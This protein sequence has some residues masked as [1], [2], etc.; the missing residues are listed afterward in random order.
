MTT[1]KT[2]MLFAD[3][4]ECAIEVSYIGEPTTTEL[5]S[6]HEMLKTLIDRRYADE[7]GGK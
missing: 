4:G 2:V 5:Y 1:D 7:K 6:A 3:F